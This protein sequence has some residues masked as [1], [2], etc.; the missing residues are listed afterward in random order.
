[1]KF[2]SD[3]NYPGQVLLAVENLSKRYG[4]VIAL[5]DVSFL[6]PTASPE[7]S[8]RT[9]RER[10]R[11]SRFYSDCSARH[12]ARRLCSATMRSTSVA[13]RSRVGYMPEHDCLPSW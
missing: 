13:V 9:A 7:F 8:A 12:P 5:N 1:M 6:S 10:A 4:N 3:P 11:R 2:G